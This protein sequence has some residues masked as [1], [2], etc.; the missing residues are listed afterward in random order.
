MLLAFVSISNVRQ[1]HL[2]SEFKS[3]PGLG[4]D[5]FDMTLKAQATKGKID[6]NSGR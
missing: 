5:S 2:T 3:P 1:V 4:G 6:E